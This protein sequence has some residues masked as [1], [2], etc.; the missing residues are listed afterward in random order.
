MIY[1]VIPTTKER[2]PQ[3]DRLIASIRENT[4]EIKHCIVL[5]ENSDGGW[6]TALHNALE[7]INGIVVLLGCDTTVGPGWLSILWQ[8][9]RKAY[10]MGNGV[11]E[12]Y[13]EL[14]NGTLCQH[15]LGHSLVIKKY[16][17]KDFVHNFSD[18]WMTDRL[19]EKGLYT[20]V[21]DAIIE[22]H[23]W[24]NKKAEHD[25]TYKKVMES[26][27][28]DRETYIRKTNEFNNAKNIS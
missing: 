17:D 11:V 4:Q 5:Y 12:G 16:L 27:D 3:T 13:N 10:P 1:I 6:V 15:P 25:E 9:Y 28:K 24:V 21:P 20:Y 18:N 23:H 19:V 26:F 2:R 14:H 7:S 22:H 8:A